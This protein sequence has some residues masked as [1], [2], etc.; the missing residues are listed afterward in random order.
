MPKKYT[1]QLLSGEGG[2]ALISLRASQMGHVYHRRPGPDAGID[3]QLELRDPLTQEATNKL[4]LVQ[5]KSRAAFPG[6]DDHGFYYAASQ[7]DIEYWMR[8]DLPVIL[9]CSHPETEEAWWRNVTEWAGDPERRA[10]RRI[11][12]DKQRDRFDESAAAE[13]TRLGVA[14]A[15]RIIVQR[16][17]ERLVSNLLE[18]ASLPPTIYIA[19]TSITSPPQAWHRLRAH[20]RHGSGW[21]LHDRS[22]LSFRDL[23]RPPFDVLTLGPPEA[24]G[25]GEWAMTSDQDRKRM[26]VRLLSQTL[27]DMHH[28]DLKFK[29]TFT[30]FKSDGGERREPSKTRKGRAVVKAIERKRGEGHYAYRHMAASLRFLRLGDTWYLSIRPDYHY[31]HDGFGKS[32]YD[33]E[34]TEGLK[35]RERNPAVRQQVEFWASFLSPQPTLLDPQGPVGP[36]IRFGQLLEILVDRAFDERTGADHERSPNDGQERLW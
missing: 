16:T 21:V 15:P 20:N 13:L 19:P 30:Y 34:L 14:D 22:V 7:A 23:S 25:T 6:E 4:L 27:R 9:V 12:F 2:E 11:H 35:R 8:A 31:T 28:Q 24:F 1:N 5:S 33:S 32:R 29:G 17:Q 26:F 18:V 3:G 10:S 36:R